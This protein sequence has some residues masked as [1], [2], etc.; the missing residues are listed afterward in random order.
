MSSNFI[1]MSAMEI[2]SSW[3][4][5]HDILSHQKPKCSW[6][7]LWVECGHQKVMAEML[8]Y[9]DHFPFHMRLFD[10]RIMECLPWCQ[11]FLYLQQSRIAFDALQQG[12]FVFKN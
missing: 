4:L 12:S 2:K 7:A 5:L 6:A 9:L 11:Q 10:M 8:D 1:S 3:C